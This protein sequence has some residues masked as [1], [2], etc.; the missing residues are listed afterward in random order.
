MKLATTTGDFAHYIDNQVESLPLLKECGFSNIDYNFDY[1]YSRKNGF[2]SE[3]WQDYLKE[4]KRV[5]A[6]C[7]ISFVQAHAPMGWSLIDTEE[8]VAATLRSIDVSAELGIK[9]IVVHSGYRP[10]LPKF[11]TFRENREFFMPLLKRAEEL[12]V[13]ILCEN[14]NKM[15][16]VNT[17]WIDNAYDL[18]EFIDYVDHP[19]LHACWDMGHG[20][21]QSHPQHEAIRLLGKEHLYALHVQDNLGDRDSHLCPYFGTLNLDSVMFGLKEIDFQG[22]FTFEVD[23]LPY[24]QAPRADF[25]QDTRLLRP[26]LELKIAAEKFLYAVGEHIIKTSC[27]W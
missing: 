18:R 23:A 6:E 25:P 22:Y 26:S 15:G 19:R 12:D 24:Y 14:F 20:N 5:A 27:D 8:M 10:H 13:Y 7:G 2:Y 21:L 16:D 17:Y 9:N 11:E 1:D 4:V 3:N